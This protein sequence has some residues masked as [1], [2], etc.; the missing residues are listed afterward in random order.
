MG[1]NRC[2]ETL[3]DE[4]LEHGYAIGREIFSSEYCDRLIAAANELAEKCGEGRLPLM[5][6]H[7]QNSVFWDA[8]SEP[9]LTS[10]ISNLV[11]GEVDGLQSESCPARVAI[12][13][14]LE[15]SPWP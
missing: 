12:R 9:L 1:V 14:V 13:S 10:K 3:V 15:K 11:A 5:Q 2:R 8:L 4:F 6:P 7:R